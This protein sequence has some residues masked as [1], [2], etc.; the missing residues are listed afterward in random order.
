[1][2]RKL[3]W[4]DPYLTHCNAIITSV[5]NDVVQ[6]DQTVAYAFNGGQESDYGTIGGYEILEAKKNGKN[7]DYTLKNHNLK[8][9]DNVTV[10]ID[11]SRRYNL[12]KNHFCGDLVLQIIMKK[13]PNINRIGA[14]VSDSKVRIDFNLDTNISNYF[15]WIYDELND[16]I[17]A[18]LPITTGYINTLEQVRFWQIPGYDKTPCGGTHIKSTKELGTVTLKRKNI[19]GGK[20]RIEMILS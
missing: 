12:M 9:N 13:Y 16:I 11:A 5:N 2:L 20:E 19:G 18:D 1:M 15:D 8:V 10:S 3:F 4:E 14:H 7:I 6:V 17:K